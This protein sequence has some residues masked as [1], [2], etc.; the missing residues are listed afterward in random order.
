MIRAGLIQ[1]SSSD[2]PARNLPVTENYIR[3]AAAGGAEFVATPENTN[4]LST[5]RAH[6]RATLFL[7]EDDPT[8]ARLRAVAQELGIWLSIGS[9][10]LKTGDADGRF[11]NR[12]FLVSPAGEA[13]ARYD[14]INMFDVKLDGGESYRE[15][16]AVR[17]GTRAVVAQ[18]PFA[19]LGLTIC[20]DLRFPQLY[21]S[22]AQAGAEIL[23]VPAAFTVPTGRA[24]WEVLLR[25]RAIETGCFVLAAAQCGDHLKAQGKARRT[26]GHSLAVSPWGEVLA[27]G[28]EEP[29]VTFIDLTLNQVYDS[30]RKIPAWRDNRSFELID[31]GPQE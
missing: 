31:G 25:A 29:G 23:L 20:Y 16:A 7:E 28:G 14:K 9:L 4:I 1:L 8:L 21:R 24:H 22:L 13:V 5:D 12:S 30:R 11:A 27:D 26:Y 18:T 19:R 10:S 15:S 17:P 2:D 6:Q 3:E